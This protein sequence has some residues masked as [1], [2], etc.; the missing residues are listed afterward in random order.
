VRIISEQA[1]KHDKTEH[2]TVL[3]NMI[4]MDNSSLWLHIDIGET[5][6]WIRDAIING[7]LVTCHD[8]SYMSNLAPDVK[9]VALTIC[10]KATKE[11]GKI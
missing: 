10:C 8:G 4:D 5:G 3:Q 6:N 11:T 7:T 9:A 1:T 2:T